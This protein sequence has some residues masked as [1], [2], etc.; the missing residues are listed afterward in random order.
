M[1]NL[2]YK[3]R[4]NS[5][6]QGKPRVF[7]CCHPEDFERYFEMV[8]DEV[9]AKQDCAIWFCDH[10]F[11]RDDDFFM[12]LKQMQLFVMPVTANLLTTENETLN[13]EFKF[14]VENHIPVLPLMQESGLDNLFNKK[15][16]DLQFLDKYS[17]DSTEISYDDKL[18]KYLES[19]L[20]GDELAEKIRAAF[21]AYVFLSYRKKDRRY[22]QELMHLIHKNEFCRDIAI[23]YDEFLIPGENFNDSIKE[24]L[25][26]SDLFVLTVT[27]NLV[28]EQNYIM[29]TEYPMAKQ[30]GKLILPAELVPTDREQLSKKYED[31]PNPADAHNE[32]EFSEALLESIKKMAIKKNDNS[33]MHNF[34]I[35]LAY[36]S[37]IDVEVNYER[38]VA[39]ITNAA[40]SGLIEAMKQLVK[41]YD[42]GIGVGRSY[43]KKITYQKKIVDILEETYRNTGETKEFIE[44]RSELSEL[45]RF[46]Y[47]EHQIES[48]NDA[49]ARLQQL[50]LE[51]SKDR[52]NNS[53]YTTSVLNAK[54][55]HAELVLASGKREE[56]LGLFLDIYNESNTAVKDMVFTDDCMAT[57]TLGL[58]LVSGS[59]CV[60]IYIGMNDLDKAVPIADYLDRLA[61]SLL[62]MASESK[63]LCT[64]LAMTF[65]TNANLFGVIEGYEEAIEC[66]EN[67]LS[68]AQKGAEMGEALDDIHNIAIVNKEYAELLKKLGKKEKA[69]ERFLNALAICEELADKEGTFYQQMDVAQLNRSLFEIAEP[70]L[71]KHYISIAYNEYK[72]LCIEHCYDSLAVFGFIETAKNRLE[73]ELTENSAISSELLVDIIKIVSTDQKNIIANFEFLFDALNEVGNFAD[74][75]NLD[76]DCYGHCLDIAQKLVSM[77]NSVNHKMA[78]KYAFLNNAQYLLKHM[79]FNDAFNCFIKT[80]DLTQELYEVTKDPRNL[81]EKA[82]CY[83]TIIRFVDPQQKGQMVQEIT[84]I[85][86]FLENSVPEYKELA[87]QLK[88]ILNALFGE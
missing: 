87:M 18:Q 78:L 42:L 32:A 26:K 9:L 68:C 71:K 23:W 39:L 21:D 50:S 30:E 33:P 17:N 29:T 45:A 37:G 5:N 88:Q 20:V 38:A 43:A 72:K 19:V 46:C 34:F 63:Q 56:A 51:N 70:S 27:P 35:G 31:I 28:N 62:P 76:H 4:R 69:Y 40:E 66:Y 82:F 52:D 36:L 55:H 86:N 83:I 61:V 49:W 67:A 79:Q 6:P 65:K 75:R 13:I 85:I 15:C 59:N 60:S 41:M 11:V 3:T 16:G 84:A 1:A 44:L 48:A 73:Y 53:I 8:S 14:A 47:D 80:V 54:L 64:A 12:D 81:Y 2:R 22:A 24:A 7:F 74:S 58:M 77:E 25:Q 57:E 10:L